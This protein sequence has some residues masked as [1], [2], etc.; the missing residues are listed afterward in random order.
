MMIRKIRLVS[1]SVVSVVSTTA[2]AFA[3]MREDVF[4]VARTGIDMK[5]L[6]R[7]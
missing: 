3:F 7:D 1:I 6:T 4:A 5:F 2:F